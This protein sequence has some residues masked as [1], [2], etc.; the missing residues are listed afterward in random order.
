MP[1][2]KTRAQAAA[3]PKGLAFA[4]DQLAA[5][6]APMWGGWTRRLTGLA[7]AGS[8]ARSTLSFGQVTAERPAATH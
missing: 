5:F 8:R 4:D 1:S 7:M 6:A 2:T 3:E